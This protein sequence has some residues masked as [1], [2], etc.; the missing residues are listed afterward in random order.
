MFTRLVNFT[1]VACAIPLA[2]PAFSAS[3]AKSIHFPPILLSLLGVP[4]AA[5]AVATTTVLLVGKCANRKNG[6][7]LVSDIIAFVLE[8]LRLSSAT[9]VRGFL[10]QQLCGGHHDSHVLYETLN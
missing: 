8:I 5:L 7:H 1:G 9:A 10:R 2:F 6:V 4:S 3:L